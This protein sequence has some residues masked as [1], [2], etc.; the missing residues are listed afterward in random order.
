MVLELVGIDTHRLVFLL[1]EKHGALFQ[2]AVRHLLHF[3]M[4]SRHH[5]AALLVGHQGQHVE[6]VL[7]RHLR[8][9]PREHLIGHGAHFLM[10]AR[11]AHDDQHGFAEQ[12]AE[13]VD[14]FAVRGRAFIQR[15]LGELRIF[16]DRFVVVGR[17]HVGLVQLLIGL[18]RRLPL[19]RGHEQ[20][21]LIH[22]T[23]PDNGKRRVFHA[24]LLNAH[25]DD[26]GRIL[27]QGQIARRLPHQQDDDQQNRRNGRFQI[28]DQLEHRFPSLL[29]FT[30]IS[31]VR[32]A[33]ASRTCPGKSLKQQD[34]LHPP[35]EGSHLIRRLSMSLVFS[36]FNC[37]TFQKIS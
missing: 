5:L 16:F 10:G 30:G 22:F 35:G 23:G 15:L 12:A 6:D 26:I 21:Q 4:D 33:R 3:V 32:L 17:R 28:L 18:Q 31:F 11:K 36:F 27:G 25:V 34:F 14:G 29:G 20:E 2:E 19:R 13:R 9:Q 8:G 24:A 37:K 7:P 1:D